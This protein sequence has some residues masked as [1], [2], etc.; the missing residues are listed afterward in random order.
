MAS[1]INADV[2]NG[3]VP[4]AAEEHEIPWLQR[5]EINGS[6]LWPS[7]QPAEIAIPCKPLS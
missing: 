5:I 7:G 2:G 4:A 1:G 3:A 6:E